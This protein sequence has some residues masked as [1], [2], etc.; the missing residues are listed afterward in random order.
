MRRANPLRQRL[1]VLGLCA[2]PLVTYPIVTLSGGEV[3]GIPATYLYLFGVWL[4]L[5][6]AAARICE[7][8]GG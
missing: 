8:K 2:I 7:G 1:V 3:A 4:A 5:I 6:G